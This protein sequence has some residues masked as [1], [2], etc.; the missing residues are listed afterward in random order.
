MRV[1]RDLAGL[2]SEGSAADDVGERSD[3]RRRERRCRERLELM[4]RTERIAYRE[5]QQ[6]AAVPGSYVGLPVSLVE[7]DPAT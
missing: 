6:G 2:Q 3:R 1:I 4:G 5:A 7:D